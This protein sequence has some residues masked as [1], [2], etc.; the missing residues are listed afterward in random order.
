MKIARMNGTLK[1]KKIE[2][3]INEEATQSD[4]AT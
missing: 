4:S 1:T 3:P 2:E